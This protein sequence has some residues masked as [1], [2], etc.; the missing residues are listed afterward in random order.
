MKKRTPI[1]QRELPDYSRGEEITNMVTHIV[2]GALSVAVLVWAILLPAFHGNPWG[3]VSGSIY[4]AC[5]VWLY[6]MSS[7]YHGLRPGR[8]KKVMQVIDHCTIYALIAGTYTPVLLAGIRPAH[9]ALAWTIFGCEWG[10]AALAATLTAIDL[11]KFKVF[12]MACYIGMGWFI[13]LAIR[14]TV[15]A[16]TLPGFLWL[17]AG[18]LAYTAG[19]VLYGLGKKRRY[20][21]SLFHVFVLVGSLLQA[22]CILF[23]V[24]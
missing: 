12:S 1:D 13:I 22:V 5:L 8:G 15:E 6:T 18:G 16:V 14:P 23:Y 21:H 24:M 3:V 10:L 9:P 7:I 20:F 19:A 17:L 4:G 2:G 11:E